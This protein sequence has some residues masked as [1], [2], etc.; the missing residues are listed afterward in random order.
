MWHIDVRPEVDPVAGLLLTMMVNGSPTNGFW[1]SS[2]VSDTRIAAEIRSY[3]QDFDEWLQW[4]ALPDGTHLAP[5]QR[6]GQAMWGRYK[7]EIVARIGELTAYVDRQQ[8][9]EQKT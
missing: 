3:S 4:P 1:M 9:G 6:Y 7:G 2:D 8:Q 5:Q